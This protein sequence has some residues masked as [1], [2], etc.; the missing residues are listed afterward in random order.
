MLSQISIQNF[1]I[2]ETLELDLQGGVT[3]FTGETGAGKSILIGALELALGARADTGVIR[4]GQKRTE[5]SAT[6]EISDQPELGDLLQELALDSDDG[7]CVL[8]RQVNADGRS[9]AFV[10]GI[11]TTRE[12][13]ARIGDL[14]VDIHGQHAHQSLLHRD[15][16]RQLLDSYADNAALLAE[17]AGHYHEWRQAHAA[18]RELNTGVP[19]RDAE[20]E[21]L[22]YQVRELEDR[23]LEAAELEQLE[24]EHKRLANLQQVLEQAQQALTLLS[25]ESRG[26]LPAVR[27]AGRTLQEILPFEAALAPGHELIDSTAIQLDE[28]VTA[29]RHYLDSAEPDPERLQEL[30]QRLGDLHDLA[31]KHHCSMTELPQHL[32]QLQQRHEALEHG[33]ERHTA[34]KAQLQRALQAYRQTTARLHEVRALAAPKLATALMENM[35]E[36]GMLD[37]VMEIRVDPQDPERPPSLSGNDRVEFLV[38]TNPG[39]PPAPL[40]KVA[41]G[42]E[43]SRISLAIQVIAAAGNGVPTLI[44]DE[45]DVGI[46]GRVAE[47]VG[48]QLRQLAGQRQVLCVTHLAQ[49]ASLGHQHL[50]VSKD[51]ADGSSHTR[52]QVLEAEQRIDEIARMMGGLEITTQTVAH[53]RDML[54]RAST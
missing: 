37:G 1:A 31:R 30:D 13:L 4:P 27:A 50:R 25:D 24:Q 38:S 49:V 46:G 9:R 12:N 11:P 48:Q 5:I 45:V 17:V 3:V 52:V 42:G 20:I 8:R 15:C 6:F 19:D 10:N 43:L 36:L 47:I 33:E 29:L 2:V 53:A 16:Q 26:A 41:S 22:R 35:R 21:L 44:F 32:K 51:N 54:D 23:V 34:L 28:A 14:L 40:S 39:Q 7:D 18:L